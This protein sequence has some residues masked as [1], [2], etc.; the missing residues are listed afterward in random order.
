MNPTLQPHP[1]GNREG[2]KQGI[3]VTGEQ[4]EWMWHAV[5]VLRARLN[6]PYTDT[7]D[8]QQMRRM[9]WE[10][11]ARED[12]LA[13]IARGQTMTA[14]LGL[15]LEQ[16]VT[17]AN[18]HIEWYAGRIEWETFYTGCMA[19]RAQLWARL[20]EEHDHG[21]RREPAQTTATVGTAKTAR[22]ADPG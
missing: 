17:A 19:A 8:G 4:L 14:A 16:M 21:S 12:V 15:V 20:R 2:E 5:Q 11:D 6:D 9:K 1:R 18:L 22:A 10:R 13:R 7:L 3:A